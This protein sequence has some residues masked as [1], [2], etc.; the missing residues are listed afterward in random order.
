MSAARF[1]LKGWHVLIALLAFFGAVI[2]VN[3]AFAV[4]AVGSFPGED[5]RRS[6]VQ[7]VHYNDTLV[8]RRAQAALG[9][10]ATAE[11]GARDGEPAVEVIVRARDGAAL[12]GGRVEGALQWPTDAR[13]DRALVFEAVGDGRYVAR[14]PGLTAGRWRL[15]GRAAAG[16]DELDFEAELTWP[17]QP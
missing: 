7:G 5:V 12:S 1:E 6:Y 3:V 2:A 13:R 11:L 17:A 14:A 4:V 15:R 8:A 9:W 10:T 16:A